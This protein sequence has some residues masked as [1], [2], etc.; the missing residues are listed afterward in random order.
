MSSETGTDLSKTIQTD[1]TNIITAITTSKSS[2]TTSKSLKTT[3][4]FT[5]KTT[6]S[7]EKSTAI[8]SKTT[9]TTERSSLITAKP[10]ST[11]LKSTPTTAKSTDSTTTQST[12]RITQPTSTTTQS[13]STTTQS[14]STTTQSS[15]TTTTDFVLFPSA[16]GV[17]GTISRIVNGDVVE[18]NSIPFIVRLLIQRAGGRILCGGS[19]VNNRWIVTAAHCVQGAITSY[20]YVGDH[21]IFKMDGPTE[22]L[23]E[24]ENIE[25]HSNF[26]RSKFVYDIALMRTKKE[27]T[28]GVGVQP[29]CLSEFEKN[30]GDEVT[31]AGWG[32]VS[33][34]GNISTELRKV[35]IDIKTDSF[36]GDLDQDRQ[37]TVFCAGDIDDMKGPC[38][39]D[40]GGPLYYVNNSRFT[41]VGVTS[42]G[43][44]GCLGVGGYVKL[45]FFK[46]WMTTIMNSYL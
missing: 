12:S 31:V 38:F 9:V 45:P 24:I 35:N 37:D 25:I 21:N 6:K 39:G 30:I 26:S 5:L 8:S 19:I 13:T 33:T 17:I 44:G 14:T 28:F 36:C 2:E 20:I 3:E 40:S 41:L 27:I 4:K 15:S 29:I 10:T 46:D 22:L 43:I 23:M 18:P 1:R 42:Y 11:L 34:T 16:C 32:R 7:T